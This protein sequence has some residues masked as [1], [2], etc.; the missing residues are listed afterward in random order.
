MHHLRGTTQRDARSP[1]KPAP[2]DN[3]P[4]WGCWIQVILPVSACDINA[5]VRVDI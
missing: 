5:S 2:G 3:R 4:Q 1:D